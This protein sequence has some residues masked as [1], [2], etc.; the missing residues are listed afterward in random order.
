M[1][2]QPGIATFM[3]AEVEGSAP[4]WESAGGDLA[5]A[6]ARAQALVEEHAIRNSGALVQGA[7][8]GVPACAVFPRPANALI[9]ALEIQRA[10]RALPAATAA[11]PRMRMAVHTAD[12]LVGRGV[13][14]GATLSRCSAL[15]ALARSGQTLVS[16][17]TADLV[18]ELSR[19]EGLAGVELRALGQRVL[20]DPSRPEEVFELS[21]AD[22]MTPD[23]GD[24]ALGDR[25]SFVGRARE[26]AEVRALIATGR[27][28]T[29]TGA[30]GSGK[31]RLAARLA[32]QV[33]GSF[34]TGVRMVD[35]AP[36]RDGALVVQAVADALDVRE[37]QAALL[38]TLAE[39]LRSQD[40]LLVLDNCEHLV[41]ATADLVRTLLGACPRLRVLATSR[42]P[43]GV[44]GEV[45]Y[46]VPPLPV[47]EPGAPAGE[48][49]A[50]RL[51]CDRALAVHP[52]FRLTESNAPA[53]AE[54]CRRLDGIPLAIELAAA[55]TDLLGAEQIVER[56]DDRLRLLTGRAP[57]SRSLRGMIDWSYELLAQ[58]ERAL[59]ER[60]AVFAGGADID[61]VEAI[62]EGGAVPA[63]G[64][65][66]L[67]AGLAG[68]SLV[69]AE[70]R[71]GRARYRLLETVR[72]YAD[73]KLRESADESETRDRHL[74]W[75][76]RLAE[77]GHE[78]LVGPSQAAWIDRLHDDHDNLRLALGR[79]A[80]RPED[81]VRLAGAL[82]RFWDIR[83]H[84]GEGRAW[85]ARA[86]AASEGVDARIRARALNA[87]GV[88]ADSQNDFRAAVEMHERAL[89]DAR[90]VDDAKLIG[91]SLTA[92][93]NA[94]RS[95]SENARARALLEE[96]LAVRREAGDE[97]GVAA[98]LNNLGNLEIAE[99]NL[100]AARRLYGQALA[101]FR[102]LGNRFA[103]QICLGNLADVARLQGDIDA[104]LRA[105]EEALRM[106]RELGDTR[107]E[108]HYLSMAGTL[109]M[110]AGD[111]DAARSHLEGALRIARE[112]GDLEAVIVC[113][114]NLGDVTRRRGDLAGAWALLE[115]SL[116]IAHREDRRRRVAMCLQQL[117]EVARDG[118]DNPRA[119][120]L[121][122][123]ALRLF[124]ALEDR[125][126]VVLALEGAGHALG[127]LGEGADGARLIG[128]ARALAGSIGL[129]ELEAAAQD[130]EMVRTWLGAKAESVLAEGERMGMEEALLLALGEDSEESS[131]DEVVGA[132]GAT[133]ST[134]GSARVLPFPRAPQ[135]AEPLPDHNR[136]RK[137]GDVWT[138][139]YEGRV[140][141]LKDA[142][143]LGHLSHLLRHPS[144]EFH[145]LD[146]VALTEGRVPPGRASTQT[147]LTIASAGDA[148]PVLDDK[149][150]AA[151][152]ARLGEL[153]EDLEEARSW[154]DPERAAAA[155]EE[156]HRLTEELARAVG[157]G[158]RDVR[159]AAVAERAR[160]SVTKAIKSAISRIAGCDKDLGRHLS[161][162]VRTG[163][164]CSY[165]PDPRLPA[166]WR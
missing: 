75:F 148:G 56:L 152:R 143:G 162:T 129:G 140:F 14:D 116:A 100:E 54:I 57:A 146:L 98:S 60:L 88:L 155:E 156:M 80:G 153:A 44:A 103:V 25:T 41:D 141:R 95:L 77:R 74:G 130:L 68:K 99:G 1:E 138:I 125:R 61:A 101:A 164:F 111:L 18:G 87:A 117:G 66:D 119:L 55:R 113:L 131:L 32:A 84:L 24:P 20:R 46:R 122:R 59:F 165:A 166:E 137:E 73:E 97:F 5:G 94:F 120:T 150:K 64:S 39:A 33:A 19:E 6:T 51:F 10:L 52:G 37:E 161:A 96:G 82:G 21:H 40:L 121:N 139:A 42:Q 104:A 144:R 126:G 35:L 163:V 123:E 108:S 128:A 49:D 109:S 114:A 67:I 151:Y 158:G 17:V 105:N 15:L 45:A 16:R 79:A 12:G 159:S 85:I 27:L 72:Q 135:P 132:G 115:E 147:G 118:E 136:F 48:S 22:L 36:L 50:V 65:L 69:V 107:S 81:F 91:N 26:L 71:H 112:L 28:V 83:G 53:V 30:G 8:P 90:E 23:G 102:G 31:T 29:L 149:A 133:W 9:C 3:M 124:A 92:L 157:L 78:E 154:D 127:R 160:S 4:L 76:I 58:P 43:L 106:A 13:L 86:L 63:G 70:E 7:R 47:P 134:P 11:P 2:M 142:R 110:R 38:D 89:R 62:C 93:G 34:R 145:V